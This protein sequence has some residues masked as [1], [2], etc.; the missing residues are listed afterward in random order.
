MEILIDG[1][2]IQ[3]QIITVSQRYDNND[4]KNIICIRLSR[5][6]NVGRVELHSIVL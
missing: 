6:Q 3:F 4:E 5:E 2:N 1:I